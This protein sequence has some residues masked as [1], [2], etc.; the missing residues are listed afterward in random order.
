MLKP[1]LPAF[2]LPLATLTEPM[3]AEAVVRTSTV[4]AFI[5]LESEAL[6]LRVLEIILLVSM[7]LQIIALEFRVLTLILL[8][9][10][11]LEPMTWKPKLLLPVP[12]S[13]VM[14][15]DWLPERWSA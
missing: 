12:E 1:L 14:S 2:W 5:L 15:R 3:V 8:A 6:E 7:T 13:L 9:M 10:M 11:M 4:L